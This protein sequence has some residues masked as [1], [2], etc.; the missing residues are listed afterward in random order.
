MAISP[1]TQLGRYEILSLLGAGGMGE[2]YLADDLT[3][4]RKVAIK[5][6]HSEVINDE[7]RLRRFELEAFSASSLNHPNILT[8]Y[9]IGHENEHHFMV[10]E[11][12]NGESLSEHLRR[13][14]LTVPEVLDVG[15]QIA[16]ALAA[17]HANGIVHRDI[18]PDNIML[19]RDH[20]VKVLDFGLA[21]LSEQEV[22]SVDHDMLTVEMALTA[23]GSVMGTARYMS[24]EQARGL[25][26]DVRTDIWSLGVVLYRMV[27]GNLPFTGNT[28]SDVIAAILT[29]E[30]RALTSYGPDMP[31]ELDRIV[32]KA[33]RKD[34]EQ[35][36]QSVKGVGLDLEALKQRLEFQ[37]ELMRISGEVK[38]GRPEQ[39][40]DEHAESVT[41]LFGEIGTNDEI[42]HVRST[43][44]GEYAVT[45]INGHKL[46]ASLILAM[47]IAATMAIAILG[48]SRYLSGNKG[49]GITSLAVLPFTNTSK[50]SER[51]IS[52][53]GSAKV[54]STVCRNCPV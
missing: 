9:E 38:G 13:D 27:S 54:S 7:D 10:T 1:G 48:Y 25:P 53:T 49:A 23:P 4:H 35:R 36:Y 8:I 40:P 18:K 34:R 52:R 5:V 31:G 19:R 43:S 21:K 20:L 42:T 2:V 44:S 32:T 17:A 26:V 11:F 22:K 29:T 50:D 41:M 28:M 37:A 46:R 51:D 14:P 6:L 3:L 33:L 39:V 12:I 16:A 24:P 45:K 47:I 15:I 30:P